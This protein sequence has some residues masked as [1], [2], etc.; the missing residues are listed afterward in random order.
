ML[1]LPEGLMRSCDPWFFHIGLTLFN[2][3][4]TTAISD[5]AGGFGLGKTTG[6]GQLDESAGVVPVPGDGVEATSLAIG[7]GNLQVSPLQVATF[8]AAIGNGGTLYRPQVIE[9]VQN[10]NGDATVAFSAEKTNSLPLKV[11]NLKVIQDAMIS[12]VQNPRGTAYIR[13]SGLNIP[14][15]GKTS[16]S[17]TGFTDPHAWFSGYTLANREDKPDIAIAVFVENGGEGSYYAAPI[18]RRIVESYFFGSP[19]TVYW[20]ESSIGVTRTPTPQSTETPVP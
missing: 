2:Q 15:A 6:I 7:Q 11:E 4:L 13:F 1:T 9:R 12:V 18:F 16:T 19:Q 20:W 3:G 8:M 14:V 5:M 17:E 10:A